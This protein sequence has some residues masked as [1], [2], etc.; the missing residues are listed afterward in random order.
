MKKKSKVLCGG[1][2]LAG[3]AYLLVNS[4]YAVETITVW[5]MG[6]EG[7]KIAQMARIFEKQNPDI[8]IVT[9]AIPWGAAHEKLMTSVVG[10]IPPDVCQ[11]GTT[12]MAEFHAMNS[13]ALLDDK[14][15]KSKIISPKKFY[16]GSWNTNVIDDKV[17]GIPWYVDT[18]VLFYRKDLLKKAGFDHPPRTWDELVK[19]AGTMARD[20]DGDGE[21]DKWG[22]NLAGGGV[23][24][25]GDLGFFVWQNGGRYLTPDNKRSAVD[26][27]EFREAFHFFVEL[28][29]K[30]LAPTKA[31]IDT[32]LFQAFKTGF[33]PMFVSGP[34]MIELTNRE[35]PEIK[36]KWDVSVLWK[37]KTRTSFVGGCNLVI[38]KQSQ[39]KEAAWRFIEF[40]SIPENQVEWY[41]L[42]AD[43]PSTRAAWKDKY[44][45]DKPMVKTFGRQLE[46][47]QSPPNIA[48]WE[49]IARTIEQLIERATWGANTEEEVIGMMKTQID[50]ILEKKVRKAEGKALLITCIVIIFIGA[51]VFFLWKRKKETEKMSFR[52]LIK[53]HGPPYV[54]IAPAIVVLFVFLILPILASLILSMTNC[55]IYTI[56]D[57]PSMSFI[58]LENYKN[59]MKDSIFWKSVVNTAIFVAVG[60]PLSI[61]LSL[62]MAVVLN[63][64]YVKLKSIFR[65]GY[66]IPVITTLVAV[67]VIWKFI[68][69]PDYGLANW[70]LD[71]IGLEGKDWL[72]STTWA[73]PSIIIMAVWKNF[74]YN[75][76]IFLAGLQ[77]IPLSLY[78]AAWCDG[79]NKW[80]SFWN[81]TVPGLRPT[82]LFVTITT[83]IGYFQFFAEPYVMTQGGPMNS[84]ISIVL[85]MYYQGFKF[86]RLGYAS[87]IAYVLFGIIFAF[88]M[89]QLKLQ[90]KYI[91]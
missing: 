53:A 61:M 41:R 15:M 27:K 8:K 89:I 69:N 31:G 6:A 70:V 10:N 64:G 13:L 23:G 47:T 50:G 1:L 52:E 40:L 66:F 79:A 77:A 81:V 43:L 91:Q 33:Y 65:A 90:K 19:I 18:R 4:V 71:L 24:C 28:F 49:Q 54:F 16:T 87:A 84:T 25:W 48:E 12:W 63:E 7:R 67:A 86:F 82:T 80:Q 76:V 51:V 30:K 56:T 68:Y 20:I 29:R 45:D 38:F 22:I 36:G 32:D 60:V 58:G 9:Q 59:L 74:G 55:D 42:T 88:T 11:L 83:L 26:T 57:W 44:F 2:L 46:D 35:C 14:I 73:L 37:G 78:E 17:Y 72:R 3:I 85:H 62:F 5:A 34:W 75:M 21:N 39:H